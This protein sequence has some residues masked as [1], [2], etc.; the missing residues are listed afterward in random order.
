MVLVLA[1]LGG[2]AAAFAVTERLKLEPSPITRVLIDKAFS[3]TCECPARTAH[4]GFGLRKSDRVTLAVIDEDGRRVRELTPP[5]RLRAGFHAFRWDGRDD[6]G[7]RVP[8]GV[9]RP[10]IHLDDARR[11]IVFPNPIEV[12]TTPPSPTLVG[13]G[14]RVFSPDGD[15]RAEGVTVRYRVDGPSRGLLLVGGEQRGR[16][17]HSPGTTGALHW[18][19]REG[20]RGLP[21]GVYRLSVAAEDSL[22]NVSEPTPAVAVRIRYVELVQPLI[23]ARPGQR[24]RLRLE[25]DAARHRWR[26]GSRSGRGRGNVLRLRAPATPGRYHLTVE[27]NGRSARG[28][29]LVSRRP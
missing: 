27:A 13:V 17:K 10:R 28:L 4:I 6:A 29:V 25:T 15:G 26:L 19:G 8:E 11:E 20:G 1:L 3:P 18:Y 24:L 5:G 16:T 9:Y 21:A 22:G 23:R 12:D 14:R 7:D 2:T